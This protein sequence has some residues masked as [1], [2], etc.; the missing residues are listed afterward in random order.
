[1]AAIFQSREGPQPAPAKVFEE[2][3]DG[4]AGQRIFETAQGFDRR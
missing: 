1:M 2:K 3:I 4:L